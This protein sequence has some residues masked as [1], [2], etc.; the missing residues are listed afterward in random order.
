MFYV[1]YKVVG[2]FAGY[3]F[4][5]KNPSMTN[6]SVG[7]FEMFEDLYVIVVFQIFFAVLAGIIIDNFSIIRSE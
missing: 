7:A 1:T 5:Y 6:F 2:G 3:L 4:Q